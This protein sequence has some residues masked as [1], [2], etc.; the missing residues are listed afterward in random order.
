MVC[1]KYGLQVVVIGHHEEALS[2]LDK[3]ISSLFMYENKRSQ[4]L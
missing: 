4:Q 3:G 1:Q 2:S